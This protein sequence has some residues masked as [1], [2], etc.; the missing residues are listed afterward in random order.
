MKE[1]IGEL[2]MS[3][4]KKFEITYIN[5]KDEEKTRLV[6]ARS[7]EWAERLFASRKPKDIKW[8]LSV[9]EVKSLDAFK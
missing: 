7:H 1:K 2:K 6:N 5:Q 9:R 3:E 4:Y 8:V